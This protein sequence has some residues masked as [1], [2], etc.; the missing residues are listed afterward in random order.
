MT[1]SSDPVVAIVEAD[2]AGETAALFAD[3][4]ATLG[5]EVVNLIWRHLATMPGA[6][7][8]VWGE[9]KPLYQGAALAHADEVR[10]SLLLPAVTAFS[11][12]TLTAAGIGA[13]DRK[14]I[15][16]IL[17]NYYHTNAL[18]LVALSSLLARF[19]GDAAPRR[20]HSRRPMPS[21]RT[22]SR[23]RLLR[24]GCRD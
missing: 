9:L 21:M 3:I 23:F 5:V 6:L 20:P 24:L 8:W 10:R 16:A 18:A 22:A 17:D 15:E 14:S 11:D 13:P 19:D 4:R 1:V 2:A 12:D 7:E